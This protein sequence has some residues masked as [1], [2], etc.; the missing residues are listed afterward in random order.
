MGTL[1]LPATLDMNNGSDDMHHLM[2]EANN[3][4]SPAAGTN[5]DYFCITPITENHGSVFGGLSESE[6]R[7]ITEINKYDKTAASV[8]TIIT[9]GVEVLKSQG[10]CT[11]GTIDGK[12]SYFGKMSPTQLK[13]ACPYCIECGKVYETTRGK[14][15]TSP[16]SLI[17]LWR[18]YA[19]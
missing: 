15:I 16:A 3:S 11:Q 19:R 17:R 7:D 14:A 9:V 18:K 12:A 4:A 1:S 6:K 10:T 5:N 13:F 8:V 2:E